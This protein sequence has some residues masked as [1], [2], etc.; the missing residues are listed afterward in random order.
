MQIKWYGHASFRITSEDGL[1]IVTDPY[2]P[3]K[4]GYKA[5]SEEVDLVIMSS[6]NDSFHCRGDLIPGSPM[7]INALDIA[8]QGGSRTEQ[9]ITFKAIE[10]MEAHDH[11]NNHPDQN[12]MYRFEV[13][14]VAFGHLGDVG[15]P[16]SDVQLAFFEGIDVLLA[17]VGGQPTI[18]LD[19]LKTVIDHSQPRVI[20]PM[21]FRTLRYKPR[22][23]LWIHHF[24]EYFNDED[25][26]FACVS[27]IKLDKATLPNKQTVIV[28][29]YA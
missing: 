29:D 16:L 19:D 21:H 22:N 8:R 10:A 2:T 1:S 27:E 15:N 4:C 6:D 28:M 3:E 26:F 23:L 12:A 18:A 5:Y 20:I 11:R 7:I 13:D 24:L 9:G 14:G 25:V 17:L